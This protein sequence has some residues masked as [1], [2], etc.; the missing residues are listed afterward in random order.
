MPNASR[1]G[2]S[3]VDKQSPGLI[4]RITGVMS[5]CN[6]IATLSFPEGISISECIDAV[7]SYLSK[8]Q[9]ETSASLDLRTSGSL[10]SWNLCPTIY[11]ANSV[12]VTIPQHNNP[13]IVIVQKVMCVEKWRDKAIN[14]TICKFKE[15]E[16]HETI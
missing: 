12:T 3:G 8:F 2:F 14:L 11:R 6:K 7:T 1:G 13:D 4:P 10:E 9:A 16:H 15:I 5:K